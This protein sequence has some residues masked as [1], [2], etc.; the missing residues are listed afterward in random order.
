[1]H[2]MFVKEKKSH[3]WLFSYL[4]LAPIIIIGIKYIY[5]FYVI[6]KKKSLLR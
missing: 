1:M 2:I 4:D 6:I 5:I 3:T